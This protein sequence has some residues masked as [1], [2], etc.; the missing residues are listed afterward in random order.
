M[1]KSIQIIATVIAILLGNVGLGQN[2][3]IYFVK[4]GVV[5]NKQSII[6]TDVDSAVFYNPFQLATLTTAIISFITETSAVSGGNITN[7]GG[8]TVTSRGICWGTSPNP[9]PADNSSINGSGAGNFASNL[10]GLL[11]GT[12]YYVRAYATNSVGTSFGN[13]LSFTTTNPVQLATLTT[14]TI[15]SITETSAVSGGN[16]TNNGGATVTSR[17]VCWGTSPNPTPADNSSVNGNGT[18]NFVSNLSGLKGGTTYYVRAYAINS[19]GTSYGDEVSFTT[20]S[21]VQLAT[22]TTATISSITETSAVSGGNITNNGGAT[23]TSRG[24]CWGTSPNPTPADNSSVNGNGTGSFVSNLSGLTNGT[25]YYVRAYATNSVGTSYG[26]EL[27][28]KT[29]TSVPLVTLTTTAMLCITETSA[30][31]GGNITANIGGG[32]IGTRGVCWGTSPNPTTEDNS[33]VTYILGAYVFPSKLSGLTEN[34]T[35]YVRAYAINSA[36][37]AYG[38]EI[39]FTTSYI[40]PQYGNG[41]TD[42]DGNIYQS[43]II[44]EQE[45]TAE[46]LR[47]SKYSDGT[48][49]PNVTDYDQ[50]GSLTTGAW[51]YYDNDSQYENDYGKLYNWYSVETGKLCPAGWHV[52]SDAEWTVL[53]D[54]LTANGA[55]GIVNQSLKSTTGWINPHDGTSANGTNDF[56]WNGVPGSFRDANWSF[57]A[58]PGAFGIYWTS[59][60]ESS[61]D[62][63]CRINFGT[64]KRIK[65]FGYSVR[66][67][68]D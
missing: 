34:T 68:K 61:E 50:W 60:E 21:P 42:I 22:L 6:S 59:N 26:N 20:T 31:S 35:Y 15:S 16:I 41:V 36:G 18:G 3:T 27:S 49:I 37:T 11:G 24:I 53:I 47:T 1:K 5:V 29:I 19:A 30:V 65:R 8:S 10:S 64:H 14:T 56:G 52:P 51:S 33:S 43:V 66:C 63:F 48:T 9:T 38:N 44:G 46:N 23:V 55:C 4:D 13:E 2:D 12:T 39:S 40:V 67:L 25:T 57:G 58:A 7:N 17:G 28:F 62:A 32:P 45:W 54:Y